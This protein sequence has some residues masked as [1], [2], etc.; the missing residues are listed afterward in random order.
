M[1][2]IKK[3]QNRIIDYKKGSA[4]KRWVTPGWGSTILSV[5]CDV[6]DQNGYIV[7]TINAK[8]EVTAWG[9]Y[10]AG[11][12]Q[13]IFNSVAGDIAKDLKGGLESK[14]YVAKK[15]ARFKRSCWKNKHPR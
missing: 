15:K 5:Q 12:W 8:G 14:G 3:Y 6:T 2:W 4:A 1:F 9:L 10:S 7:G 11:A 13:T